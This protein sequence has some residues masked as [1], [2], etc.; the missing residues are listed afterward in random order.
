LTASG[1]G[2]R[3]AG[4]AQWRTE[5]AAPPKKRTRFGIRSWHAPGGK[6]FW[7]L[8]AFLLA[9]N[10]WVAREAS[11]PATRLQV[12]YTFF[13]QEVAQ[14]NVAEVTS[15]A[16][17][18]EGLF[19]SGVSFNGKSALRFETRRP[20]FADDQLLGMLIAQ[21]VVVN[22][23]PP[24]SARP[25]WMVLL[26]SFAP[27]LLIVGLIF[28]VFRRAGNTGG[29]ASLGRSR[30]K[31]YDASGQRT[32][33]SDVAGID[34]VKDELAEIV[35]YLRDPD[36]YERLG[37]NIPR[38]VLLSGSPGT[39]K[40][41]L[42]RAVA[43]E[44]D[45][46]FYSISA[47]EFVEMVAG[48]GASRVRD[49]FSQA[50]EAAPAIVFIDELD[51]IGRARGGT[52][53][54]VGSND[55]REQTLN[56]ILTEMDGFSGGDGVIVIA[57]TN[58]P[59]IL[60]KALMR[61]GRFDRRVTVSAPDQAGR[62]RILAV[63]TRNVPLADDVDLSVIASTAPGMVGADLKNLVNEAALLAARR[64]HAAVS[65]AEFADALEKV[66][67]GAERRITIS[68]HERERTAYHEAGHALLGMLQPGADPVR[69]VSIVP[70]GDALGVTFQSPDLDRYGYDADYLHGRII[71]LLG[72]R[73]AEELVYGKVTSG[74]ENDLE[75]VTHVARLMVG[76]WGMSRA[77]GLMSALPG[78]DGDPSYIRGMN[79]GVSEATHELVDLEV[80]RLVA[81]CY[82]C[83]LKLLEDH[84]DKLESLASALLERETLDEP[85]AYEAAGFP[86]VSPPSNG[87]SPA[88]P[89]PT[90]RGHHEN[91]G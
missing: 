88:T 90:L 35:D 71:G 17:Q 54:R 24:T 27:S 85:A 42:A 62:A 44:A 4:T 32:N 39:G 26:T 63:H 83:S 31:L 65:A 81:E 43:G 66:V 72:G 91:L 46:P 51:A 30:A 11:R 9:L 75:Q 74:A 20:A 64:G 38:G 29:I 8:V 19:R 73:A 60:D 68:A 25:L 18:I 7:I 36:R 28:Y 34:E 77:V 70:R 5:G 13:R 67:L 82:T 47:S 61:P 22:A 21:R 12:P 69:K 16:D 56:Q 41:L 86:A 87:K 55:E 2:S 14:G 45:V 37:A 10:W 48:V 79:R 49:L 1:D 50:K 6:R 84:R 33:F 89:S 40:T 76:R 59:E 58:R 80:R 52:V 15:K 23:R 3:A 57:A 78:G 53:G